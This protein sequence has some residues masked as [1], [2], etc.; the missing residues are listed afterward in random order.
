MDLGIDHVILGDSDLQRGVDALEQRTGVRAAYGGAH[1]GRGTHNALLSLGA[2]RYL[3]IMAP[4]P[5]Q[6]VSSP[7]IQELRALESLTPVG[8]AVAVG[9]VERVRGDLEGRGLRL[10]PTQ[11]GSR[12][13]PDGTRLEWATFGVLA[14]DHPLA[15]FFIHWAAGTAHPSATSPAGCTLE[16]LRLEDPNPADLQAIVDPLGLAVPVTEGAQSRIGMALSCPRGRIE[17]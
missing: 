5:Q 15:P 12:A 2:G 17:F 10:S 16:S 13:R 14:P 4:D 7:M 8:W 11:P 3:E 9:D 6:Q 1:P